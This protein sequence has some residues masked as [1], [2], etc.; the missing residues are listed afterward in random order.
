MEPTKPCSTASSAL[1]YTQPPP[2]MKDAAP[3]CCASSGS[4][5]GASRCDHSR[6]TAEL[7]TAPARQSSRTPETRSLEGSSSAAIARHGTTR[8]AAASGRLPPHVHWQSSSTASQQRGGVAPPSPRSP[9]PRVDASTASVPRLS[10]RLATK[11]HMLP[12]TGPSE[13]NSAGEVLQMVA[14]GEEGGAGERG[15]FRGLAGG[16]DQRGQSESCGASMASSAPCSSS[17]DPPVQ[18]ATRASRARP[19]H[20]RPQAAA[21]SSSLATPPCV[22][23]PLPIATAT[24]PIPTSP[25]R[26]CS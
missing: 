1:V 16:L 25:P 6:A 5:E 7:P 23:P 14:A 4:R 18:V 12:P 21:S 13:G 8:K 3:S 17:S 24:S 15:V 20:R 26:P 2:E 9:P 11:E 19:A 22:P 10:H